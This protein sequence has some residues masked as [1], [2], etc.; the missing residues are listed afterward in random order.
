MVEISG[1]DGHADQVD[2]QS[3]RGDAGDLVD[4]V[5]W[6]DL[7]HV[8]PDDAALA[9][10]AVDQLARLVE[11]DAAGTGC[12]DGRRDRRVH[13]VEIDRQVIASA[14][15]DARQDRVHADLVQ[16]PCGDQM[17]AVGACGLDFF[18]ART[19]AGAQADLEDLADMGHFGSAT[20]RAGQ[21]LA[22]AVH[23]VAPVDVLVDLDQRDRALPVECLQ[24][25]DRHAVVAAQHDRQRAGVQDLAHRLFGVAGV[26][27]R[28]AELG[29]DVAAIHRADRLA[30]VERATEVEVVALDRADD[31]G[32]GLA[33]RGGC[34]ALVVGDVFV[35]VGL[36]VG[37][38]E[39]GDVGGEIVQRG[40]RFGIEE[41]AGR[42]PGWLGR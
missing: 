22:H 20:D 16:F 31:A 2:D 38:A 21:A 33:H 13:A 29:A 30:G 14:I 28:V 15:R 24:H 10:Q 40:Y 19:A 23:L 4:V 17:G 41:G 1:A 3:S 37:D 26:C 36:R 32:R 8:H 25:R 6:R 18:G 27:G 35:A 9:H 5:A 42:A 34:V 11:G 39:I 12:R 7:H